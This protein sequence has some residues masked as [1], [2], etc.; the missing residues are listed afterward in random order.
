MLV[1]LRNTLKIISSLE[2]LNSMLKEIVIIQNY[3]RVDR[4]TSIAFKQ[5][6]NSQDLGN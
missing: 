6:E 4:D 1:G 2:R 5:V 3:R